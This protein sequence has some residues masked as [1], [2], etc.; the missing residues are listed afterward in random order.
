MEGTMKATNA[1]FVDTVGIVHIASST[2]LNGDP[3]KEI[4][5]TVAHVLAIAKAAAATPTV[6]R[7]V[8]TGSSSGV[9]KPC[10]DKEFTVDQNSFAD[11]SIEEAWN[12]PGTE[13]G[14]ARAYTIYGA[15]KASAE[16]A[17]WKW[18]NQTKPNMLVNVG[19]YPLPNANS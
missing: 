4:P 14:G 5:P 17:F 16:K 3:N 1:I 19:M 13:T 6:Q 9:Y 18:Y 2:A 7:F 8:L 15:S 11:Q 10:A 12:D